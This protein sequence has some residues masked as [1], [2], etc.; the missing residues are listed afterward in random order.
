MS[1]IGLTTETFPEVCSRH[2]DDMP[3]YH[4]RHPQGICGD[5]RLAKVFDA[6]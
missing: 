4:E 2:F 3:V 5:L 1:N 6:L